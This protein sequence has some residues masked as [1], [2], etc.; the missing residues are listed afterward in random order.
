MYLCINLDKEYTLDQFAV[1]V[2]LQYFNS[3]ASFI[4]ILFYGLGLMCCN[5]IHQ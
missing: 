4:D 5:F 1:A 2:V 3:Q